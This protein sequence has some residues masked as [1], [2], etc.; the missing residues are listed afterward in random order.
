MSRRE[1]PVEDLGLHV[2]VAAPD[3]LE[4]RVSKE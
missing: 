4:K 3:R 2:G 1:I